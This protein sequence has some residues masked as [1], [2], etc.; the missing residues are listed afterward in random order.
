MP[1]VLHRHPTTHK[2]IANTY[3]I[4][5]TIKLHPKYQHLVNSFFPI[6]K[7]DH[8]LHQQLILT[9]SYLYQ[10]IQT[11]HH[12]P[13]SHML[14]AIIVIIN[15]SINTCNNILAHP[16]VYHFNIERTNTL[17]NKLVTLS[18]PPERHIHTQHPYTKFIE[19]HQN[20]IE[21]L[22]SIHKEL[23]TFIHSHET[24]PTIT[25]LQ[26]ALPFLPNKLINESLICFETL[27][28][29]AHPPPLLNIPPNN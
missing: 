18:N 14:Y 5:N 28:E 16:N 9:F 20:I 2:M 10:Y 17:I 15:P 4:P 19:S 29:Y 27:I 11:Q 12:S 24:P 26:K 13:L 22:N 23:Y 7:Q 21:P 3:F 25:V 8:P 1:N 6:L